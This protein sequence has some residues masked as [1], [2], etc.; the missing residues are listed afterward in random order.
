MSKP[1]VIKDY[2]KLSDEVKEQ[3]KLVYPRGFAHHLISFTNRNGEKKMGLPFETEDFYYLI[4]MTPVRAEQI[5]ED[6]DDFDDDGVLKADVMEGYTEKYV[7]EESLSLNAN[8]DN[9]FDIAD[10]DSDDPG[11]DDGDDDYGDD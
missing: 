2:D 1:K 6:D 5:I 10:P 3:I 11:D 9:E 4:R 8:D 7:D